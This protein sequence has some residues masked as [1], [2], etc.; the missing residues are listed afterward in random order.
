MQQLLGPIQGDKFAVDQAA[1]FEYF[2]NC[3]QAL[4]GLLTG[5]IGFLRSPPIDLLQHPPKLRVL[6]TKPVGFLEE[7]F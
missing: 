7:V 1:L 3:Q 2:L 5:N 4:V 6:F